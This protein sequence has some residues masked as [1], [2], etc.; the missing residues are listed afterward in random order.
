M[1][2]D[3]A[4][5]SKLRKVVGVPPPFPLNSHGRPDWDQIDEMHA[6]FPYVNPDFPDHARDLEQAAYHVEGLSYRF[7]CGSYRNYNAWRESLCR[8]A[9]RI[10][11]QQIW[12]N[13]GAFAGRPFV[14]LINFSDC[15]GCIG[16]TVAA[17]LYRDFL[18]HDE[19]L[20]QRASDRDQHWEMYQDFM[21][22]FELAQDGGF[23]SFS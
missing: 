9:L 6:V 2:L 3:I 14:E 8:K 1:G 10:L 4:A 11:P 12:D 18:D 23:V 5:H 15:E 20:I 7:P 17:K 13:P 22:A 19:K 16:P 21:R